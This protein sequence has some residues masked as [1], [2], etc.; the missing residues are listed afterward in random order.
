MGDFR[1]R[2]SKIRHERSRE[3]M[4]RMED[5]DTEVFEPAIAAV[6]TECG[7]AGHVQ[8]QTQ[9]NGLGLNFIDC[10]NCGARMESWHDS[11]S[12]SG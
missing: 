12:R 3:M 6:R 10:R 2:L 4:R 11:V 1:S 7:A 9:W 5:Y 8:G